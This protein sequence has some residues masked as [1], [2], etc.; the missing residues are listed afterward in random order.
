MQEKENVLRILEG[1]KKAI[2]K[3]DSA[4]LKSLSNQTINTAS[5]TQDL[6]NI[7][8][9]VL[10]YSLSKIIERENYH[11][12]KGWNV[13]YK[14]LVGFLDRLVEDVKKNDEVGFRKDFEL[15]RKSIESLSGK[16]KKYIEEV[17]RMAEVN[18]ASRI[19]AHGISAEQTAQLLGVTLYELA[20]Y[21]GKSGISDVPESRTMNVKNRIKLVEEFFG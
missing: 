17:F 16:L 7:A 11:K 20:E 21:S 2:E 5:L 9:A 15:I 10:V 13:F 6:D 19:Y 12:L 3:G 18:K 8:V 4:V 1:T 14:K